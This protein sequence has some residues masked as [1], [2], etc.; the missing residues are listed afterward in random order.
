MTVRPMVAV[1]TILKIMAKKNQHILLANLWEQWQLIYVPNNSYIRLC[2]TSMHE[3]ITDMPRKV[4]FKM[5]MFLIAG[6][7]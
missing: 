6:T 7:N 5:V 3:L 4:I 1:I 2:N